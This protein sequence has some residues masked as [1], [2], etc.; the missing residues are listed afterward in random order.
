MVY[1]NSTPDIRPGVMQSPIIIM[2]KL[3]LGERDR[4]SGAKVHTAQ[5]MVS[6]IKMNK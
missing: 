6:G 5:G 1:S 2:V 3:K 4:E